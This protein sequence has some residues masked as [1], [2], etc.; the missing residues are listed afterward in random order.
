MLLKKSPAED[1]RSPISE[2][3]S[4]HEERPEF[5]NRM[6]NNDGRAKKKLTILKN[7]EK[8]LEE[9]KLH[10]VNKRYFE[11]KRRY[12]LIKVHKFFHRF[13]NSVEIDKD[14]T[15]SRN[16]F[17]IPFEC[18]YI[19]GNIRDHLIY[20]ANRNSDIERIEHFFYS[21]PRYGAEL[22]HRQKLSRFPVIEFFI[23]SWRLF[24]DIAYISVVANN[25]VMLNY[26]YNTADGSMTLG[27]QGVN[28]VDE[29]NL[30]FAII[31]LVLSILVYVFCI[32]ERYPIS[33]FT[34]KSLTETSK[35]KNLLKSNN[36]VERNTKSLFTSIKH[37]FTRYIWKTREKRSD[38]KMS[39]FTKVQRI[40]MDN[41]NLYNFA[42]LAVSITAYVTHPLV[43]S[44]L[45][46]DIVKRSEDLQ[47]I[48]RSITYNLSNLIKTIILGLIVMY[49]YAIIGFVVFRSQ[50]NPDGS[51][52]HLYCDTLSKCWTSTIDGVRLGGGLGDSLVQPSLDDPTN[53]WGRWVFDLTFFILVNIILLNIIF[54]III[55]T[56][57][58][59]RD[60]RKE[61]LKDIEEKC[62]I[63]SQSRYD[64]DT[65]GSG[66]FEHIYNEHNVYSYLNYIIYIQK[67]KTTDCNGV[68]KYVKELIEQKKIDFIPQGKALAL[69]SNESS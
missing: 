20:E 39:F 44:I 16:Y 28:T 31:Q 34:E 33:V 49:F 65:K 24:K 11:L 50:Y 45:L 46:L 2:A 38:E 63:C 61:E 48:I 51:P 8:Q 1:I 47:N 12:T 40:F 41:Q 32:I 54:G 37:F 23:Q 9:E 30:A 25:I 62:F 60:Q 36:A 58:D 6:Q 26:Q 35:K 17:Q 19:T 15:L 57:G 68:E 5:F 67:K 22:K 52:Y 10:K 7:Y 55:D 3:S 18:D 4:K 43:Y 42:Y 64:F 66:W 53:Y 13:V 59:L 21:I 14:G 69:E 27:G 56:F 29:L